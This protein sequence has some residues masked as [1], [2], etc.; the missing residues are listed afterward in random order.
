MP[1][2][3]VSTA[4][5]GAAVLLILLTGC[6]VAAPNGLSFVAS[7]A[8]SSYLVSWEDGDWRVR[9][10]AM[11]IGTVDGRFVEL[12]LHD[13]DRSWFD[14][15]IVG[16]RIYRRDLV[17]GDSSLIFSDTVIAAVADEYAAAN[18]DERPLAPD[19]DIADD[20]SVVATTETELLNLTGPFLSYEY[21]A[22]IDIGGRRDQHL[23]IR[24]VL[25][26]RTGVTAGVDS[27]AATGEGKRIF[28][29]ALASFEAARDS[30]RRGSDVR[31]RRA[32]AAFGGFVFDSLS[33][34]ITTDEPGR[35]AI[36]FL[37]PGRGT[38]AG[39]FA[40][41]LPTIPFEPG[42]WTSGH[43]GSRPSLESG[44][45]TWS[46]APFTVVSETDTIGESSSIVVSRGG[47]R[48]T[49]AVVGGVGVGVGVVERIDRV[50][51]GGSRPAGDSTF[52][53]LAR[54]FDEAITHSGGIQVA[55]TRRRPAAVVA[56]TIAN[57][58][59]KCNHELRGTPKRSS[60][61][62]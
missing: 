12:Y 37:V 41:P 33:F 61:T 25:D 13:D 27:I 5:V 18:P 47:R 11:L 14:A 29:R 9:R 6:D 40:L 36:A 46:L 42:T 23:T 62:S 54:A 19:E 4:S 52:R 2:P 16:Q 53:A 43:V 35:P 38:R 1:V 24:R 26:S 15:L 8:D 59:S 55:S 31:A 28:E 20:P 21:H 49:V 30:V 50:V 17:S 60:R 10:S 22:D 58:T 7:T 3:M 44:R 57:P 39:G 32:Q 51:R 45:P 34:S 48:W 56:A